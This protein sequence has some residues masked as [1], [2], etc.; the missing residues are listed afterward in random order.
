MFKFKKKRKTNFATHDCIIK[1]A[2][3]NIK[4][5][6]PKRIINTVWKPKRGKPFKTTTTS[7]E[8]QVE[9]ILKEIEKELGFLNIESQRMFR[10][11]RTFY[12]ADFYLEKVRLIVEIDGKYHDTPKQVFRDTMRDRFFR[13]RRIKTV[14]IR[15]EQVEGCK[16]YLFNLISNRVKNRVMTGSGL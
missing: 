10:N 11:D 14:R 3:G 5:I 15:N 9:R 6:I 12:I 2:Q 16:T 1:D 7:Y 13:V 4:Q 8:K